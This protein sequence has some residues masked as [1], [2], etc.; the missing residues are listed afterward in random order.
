MIE[1]KKSRSI[2]ITYAECRQPAFLRLVDSDQ[3][4]EGLPV[5]GFERCFSID[6]RFY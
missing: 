1:R 6:M 5:D 3:V 4:A 2:I